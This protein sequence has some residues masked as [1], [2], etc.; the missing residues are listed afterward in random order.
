MKRPG[1][2]PEME[3]LVRQVREAAAQEAERVLR[4]AARRIEADASA[5]AQVEQAVR[6]GVHLPI[7]LRS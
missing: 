4:E 5:W 6:D 1:T 7:S 3:A 2:G